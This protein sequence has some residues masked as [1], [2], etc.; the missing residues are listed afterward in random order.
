MN[1]EDIEAGFASNAMEAFAKT[2]TSLAASRLGL[3]GERGGRG[4]AG[5][6]TA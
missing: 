4:G 1:G 5:G 3:L 2:V 6:A